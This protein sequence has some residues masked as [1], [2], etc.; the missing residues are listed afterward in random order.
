MAPKP[1]RAAKGRSA[2]NRPAG[3]KP[4]TGQTKKPASRTAKRPRR[5]RRGRGSGT[6]RRGLYWLL[7]LLLALLG[8]AGAWFWQSRPTPSPSGTHAAIPPFEEPLHQ[9]DLAQRL[10]RVDEALF[11]GLD[12]AGLPAG[13]V[14]LKIQPQPRGELTLV[15]I[16]LGPE[17]NAQTVA[18]VLRQALQ[19]K[20]DDL[21]LTPE[22]L[23]LRLEVRLGDRLTHLVSLLPRPEMSAPP[24]RPERATPAPAAPVGR[25]P[26][27]AAPAPQGR[28]RLAVVIDDLGYNLGAAQRLA[29]L[30]LPLTFSILP[31]AP[32]AREIAHLAQARSLEIL[33]HMPM[34]PRSYPQLTPGPGALLVAMSDPELRRQTQAN[35]AQ[36]PGA[37]GVNNHMGSR[38]TE[39]PKALQPVLEVIRQAGL[40]FLDSATSPRSQAQDL[41]RR[42]GLPQGQR[43]IFLDHDPGLPAIERQLERLLALA[44][45]RGQA[46]AI[47]HPGADTIRALEQYAGRLRSEVEMV[48]VSHL[49]HPAR[50]PGLDKPAANP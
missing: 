37:V 29:D 36:V 27:P 6:V 38:F 8:V 22:G 48:P 17:Q 25:P 21:R 10:V 5:G 44:R 18:G 32:H 45:G 2:S 12:R 13:A 39:N 43:D 47:G 11:Q 7:G 28:P 1:A 4:R 14:S 42:M 9:P 49:I 23:G 3:A 33:V 46:I 31:R 41:A 30:G 34:E 16:R 50:E 24:A 26:A 19:S 35:L 15:S 40:F 20:A